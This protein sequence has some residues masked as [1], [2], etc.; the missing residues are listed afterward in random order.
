MTERKSR[1]VRS[2]LKK[3]IEG[4]RAAFGQ[5]DISISNE[6]QEGILEYIINFVDIRGDIVTELQ[7]HPGVYA[8]IISI[9]EHLKADLEDAEILLKYKKEEIDKTIDLIISELR[10]E[11]RGTKEK[12]TEVR[13]KEIA[14]QIV[15]GIF[16]VDG[17]ENDV[18]EWVTFCILGTQQLL[19]QETEVYR[20]KRKLNFV[21][22]I[23][24]ALAYQKNM[25]LKALVDLH[26]SGIYQEIK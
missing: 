17:Y 3:E 22:G 19:L 15:S 5:L 13:K 25:A 20:A 16:D 1:I 6:D 10:E 4:I 23:C 11:L 14:N 8:Y 2:S 12:I 18:K 26:T 21:T 24:S 9:Q 7:N